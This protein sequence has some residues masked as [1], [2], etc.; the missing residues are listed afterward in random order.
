[1]RNSHSRIRTTSTL[2]AQEEGQLFVNDIVQYL[3]SLARLHS[4]ERTG[5]PEL[6]RGL[7]H[8]A[9]ALR[10][11]ANYPISELSVTLAQKVRPNNAKV[12]HRRPQVTLPTDL[13]SL[14]Q[15]EIERI[16]EDHRYTKQQVAELGARRFGM[17]QSS[18]TRLRKDDALDSV[19][20]ALANE[21][22]H[23]IIYEE[24]RRG[25]R[26]QAI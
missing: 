5:N 4:E 17:S 15:S 12:A 6:S 7:R 3:S 13:E 10:P 23:D 25:N 24:A 8:L 20:A 21:Q 18:L 1:M 9:R 16:L 26:A 2:D 19:R 11:Y 14:D 22:S